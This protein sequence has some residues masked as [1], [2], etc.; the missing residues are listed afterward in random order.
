[1]RTGKTARAHAHL[2]TGGWRVKASGV[3]VL[4]E[5]APRVLSELIIIIEELV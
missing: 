5:L 4:T 3:G 1:V 2:A